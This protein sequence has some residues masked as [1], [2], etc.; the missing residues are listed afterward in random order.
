[1]KLAFCVPPSLYRSYSCSCTICFYNT[2]VYGDCFLKKVK[3][4]KK[5]VAIV[6]LFGKKVSLR[7]T[8][9]DI[10]LSC[11]VFSP[12][13]S[14]LVLP[15]LEIMRHC[16]TVFL[17]DS[18]YSFPIFY[19]PYL[20]RASIAAFTEIFLDKY[21]EMCCDVSSAHTRTVKK[22]KNISSLKDKIYSENCRFGCPK[23]GVFYG[24]RLIYW[25]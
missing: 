22:P 15:C 21:W 2:Y 9:L 25:L 24:K 11:S 4:F 16:S 6:W 14:T 5:K 13:R 18:Y 17:W 8:S 7:T 19:G 23:R 20:F 3:K 1:M 12:E 10:A